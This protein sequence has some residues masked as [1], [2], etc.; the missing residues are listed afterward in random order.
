M[1]ALRPYNDY[2]GIQ[3]IGTVWTLT[4]A[5]RSAVCTVRTYPLGWGTD[6]LRGR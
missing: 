5:T 2:T 3:I 4:K 6:R 1:T